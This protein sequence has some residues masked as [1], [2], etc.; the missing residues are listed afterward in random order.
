MGFFSKKSTTKPPSPPKTQDSVKR[1]QKSKLL[2]T[3][4]YLAFSGVHDDTL[5]LKNGGI[6]AVLSVSAININLKSEEEQNAIIYS[7]QGFLNALE[8]PVQILAQSRKL[9]I[10]LY[11]ENLKTKQK[12]QQNELLKRQMLEYIEYVQKLVEFADIMEKRFYVVIPVDPQRAEK[13]SLW[14]KFFDKINPDETLRDVIMRKQ[15]FE[16]LKKTLDE[17]VNIV[18]TGLE[19]CRLSTKKLS[20]EAIIELFY[21]TYNPEQARNQ[22]LDHMSE[23]MGGQPPEE[24]LVEEK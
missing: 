24:A 9:D 17:R 23:I 5:I 19:N 15:E 21:Q 22:R 11:V 18:Q 6:R 10:D 13:K 14:G 7:F 4:R 2:S 1:G 3:Q 8:F 20:T 16:V 12:G